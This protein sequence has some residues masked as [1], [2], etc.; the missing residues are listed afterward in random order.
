[1]SILT[2]AL[3]EAIEICGKHYKI[4]TDFRVWL[5]VDEIMRDRKISWE[6]RIVR[7]IRLCLPPG[8]CPVLPPSLDTVTKRI[9]EFYSCGKKGTQKRK[10][11]Q[12]TPIF[13]YS[14]DAEYI[15]ASFYQQYG[16]DLTKTT[17]HWWQFC[18]LFSGLSRD[19]QIMQIIGYRSV[20][21]A[22]IGDKGRRSFYRKMKDI[23][24]LA[25]SRSDEERESDIAEALSQ[26]I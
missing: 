3:P 25:D 2:E 19:T 20:N 7:I 17:L 24:R 14:E 12:K 23:Y 8:D 5:M 4:Q 15:Y 10:G 11:T 26:L 21:P 1:M 9:A 13:S 22:E 18:A 6:E 16:I